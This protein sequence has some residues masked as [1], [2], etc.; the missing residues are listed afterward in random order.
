MQEYL[1]L[2][3]EYRCSIKILQERID[4]ISA[5]I[6]RRSA[7]SDPPESLSKRRYLLYCE[8]W[9]MQAAIRELEEYVEARTARGNKKTAS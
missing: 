9:E 4:I 5:E 3:A 2:I 7:D 8:I 1:E 6:Q